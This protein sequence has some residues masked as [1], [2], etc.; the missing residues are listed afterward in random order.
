M[1]LELS[2]LSDCQLKVNGEVI[3]YK[4]LAQHSPDL[5]CAKACTPRH[6][7]RKKNKQ[8]NTSNLLRY[9]KG[10]S[11]ISFC[12]DSVLSEVFLGRD[13][14]F[15]FLTKNPNQLFYILSEAP[16]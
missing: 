10:I 12:Y 1:Q 11:F 2:P 13:F 5:I 3:Q 4:N 14:L 6:R 9:P 7:K 15:T 16:F 8:T